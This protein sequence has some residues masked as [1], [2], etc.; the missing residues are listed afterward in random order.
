MLAYFHFGDYL[1][2]Y[3][4]RDFES[5]RFVVTVDRI[6]PEFTELGIVKV[7]ANMNKV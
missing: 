4:G 3:N 5:N 2:S 7:L 1:F 6:I